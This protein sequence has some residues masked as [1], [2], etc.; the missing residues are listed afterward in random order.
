MILRFGESLVDICRYFTLAMQFASVRASGDN[1]KFAATIHDAATVAT[2][3]A[4]REVL[5]LLVDQ[6]RGRG[7]YRIGE[8]PRNGWRGPSRE[9]VTKLRDA[10]QDVIRRLSQLSRDAQRMEVDWDDTVWIVLLLEIADQW[11]SA[12]KADTRGIGW[13]A[14]G[15]VLNLKLVRAKMEFV[16]SKSA[17]E[18]ALGR[19]DPTRAEGAPSS[20]DERSPD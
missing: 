4:G 2:L 18:E 11:A 14:R 19:S 9:A 7:D 10:R 16:R 15:D 13:S 12:L 20:S 1:D 6:G 8:F 17:L 5:D 3:A